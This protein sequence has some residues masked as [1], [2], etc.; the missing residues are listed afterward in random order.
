MKSCGQHFKTSRPLTILFVC[1]TAFT[2]AFLFLPFA[3]LAQLRTFDSEPAGA[4]GLLPFLQLIGPEILFS[5]KRGILVS[6]I[7]VFV[8]SF[9]AW[10]EMYMPPQTRRFFLFIFTLPLFLSDSI[11][12][13]ALARAL[14]NGGPVNKIFSGVSP[15]FAEV[16]YLSE[17]SVVIGLVINILPSC[18]IIISL[19]I[20]RA[21][22]PLL[23]AAADT[24]CNAW[25]SFFYI[26]LPLVT[27]ALIG[28][29]ILVFV[30]TL[31]RSTEVE[32]LGGT[33]K[34]SLSILI[35][36]FYQA[37]K[38]REAELLSILLI[39]ASII[40]S[41]IALKMSRLYK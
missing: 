38:W 34:I 32:F 27:P 6:A 41:G 14:E 20:P 5:I 15:R 33:R 28:T 12:S 16:L 21:I 7:A 31:S 17:I 29:A 40:V 10:N 22:S 1:F 19:L 26:F 8:G 23:K 25:K 4:F 9:T 30:Q 2:V 24:G 18:L 36:S 13:Y 11:K 3:P 39:V 37:G 35:N